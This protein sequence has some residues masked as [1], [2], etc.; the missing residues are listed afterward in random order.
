MTV[1]WICWSRIIAIGVRATIQF[2]AAWQGSREPTARPIPIEASL[3]FS[4]TT[5]AMERLATFLWPQALEKFWLKAW[6]WQSQ[7]TMATGMLTLSSPT[8]MPAI[9]SFTTWVI[10][11]LRRSAFQPASLIMAMAGRFPEWEQT[12]VT[13]METGDQISS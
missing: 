8:T 5:M 7:I 4:T 12:F 2:V 13:T 11:D 6:A 3:V 9:S 10:A 1:A